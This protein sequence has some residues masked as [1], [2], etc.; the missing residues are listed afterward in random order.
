MDLIKQHAF[1]HAGQAKAKKAI[2]VPLNVDAIAILRKQIG[3]HHQFVF[4]YRGQPY[5]RNAIQKHGIKH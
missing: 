2:P 5:K 3:K 1:I 4:T